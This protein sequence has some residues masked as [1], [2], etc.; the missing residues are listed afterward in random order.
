[1]ALRSSPESDVQP[2]QV[3]KIFRFEMSI[4]EKAKCVLLCG[5]IHDSYIGQQA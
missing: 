5:Y 1:M 2:I 3:H 4:E